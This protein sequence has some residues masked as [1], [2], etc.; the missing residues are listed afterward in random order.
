LSI[1]ERVIR[2]TSIEGGEQLKNQLKDI[3]NNWRLLNDKLQIFEVRST[4]EIFFH[5]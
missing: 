1:N 5:N 2:E 4:V 3:E